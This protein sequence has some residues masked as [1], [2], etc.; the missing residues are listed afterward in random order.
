MSTQDKTIRLVFP[1]WQ[2]GN[3]PVYA[4]GANLLEWLAPATDAPVFHVPVK[5]PGEPLSV[6]EGITGRSEINQHLTDAWKII[7]EQQPDSIVTLGGDCLVSL[8]PFAWLSEKYGDK[9]GVLWIDS[10][11]DIQTP[12]QFSNAHAHVLG[13]LLGYGDPD[14]TASVQHPIAAENVMIAGI[15]DPL[16]HE[17]E[18]LAE[19]GIATCSPESVRQGADEV[20][21]WMERQGIEFLAIHFDLDVL[22]PQHFRSV[23]FAQPGRGKNDFGGVAEGELT[24]AEVLALVRLATDKAKPVGLTLAEHLPWDALHLKNMLESLPLLGSGK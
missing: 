18:F 23:L 9:L 22:D 1:L 19:K 15:H 3:N 2:G 12:E 24:M 13:A 21:K 5:A 4:L 11:P 14:L 6:E 17:A 10:H 16:P 20:T 8:A 7:H